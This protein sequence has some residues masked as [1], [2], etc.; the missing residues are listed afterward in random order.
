[1]TP[2]PNFICTKESPWAKGRNAPGQRVEHPDAEHTQ[3]TDYG[4]GCYCAGYKCPNCG[5][6]FEVELPQ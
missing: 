4:L 1:M 2:D 6:T 5:H 3:D